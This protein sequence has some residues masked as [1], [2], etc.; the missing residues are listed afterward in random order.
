MRRR[1][2]R[3]TLGRNGRANNLVEPSALRGPAART[4]RRVPLDSCEARILTNCPRTMS[5]LDATTPAEAALVRQLEQARALHAE[6]A[7]NP[8]LD[9][10]MERLAD[11]QSRRLAQTYA[12]LAAQ[13]RYRQ[14]IAFFRSDL[15]GGEEMARARRGPRARRADAC[16][17]RCPSASS[18]RSRSRWSSTCSRRSSIGCCSAGCRAPTA[19]SRVAE[20]C[21]AYRRAANLPARRRQI[22]LIGA[23]RQGARPLREE[24]DGARRACDDA[25]ARAARRLRGAARLPR[26]GL[27]CVRSHGR[28]RR[29]P[30]DDPGARDRDP[31]GD[32]RRRRTIRS[33]IR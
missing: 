13:P 16:R 8:I 3:S 21:R 4:L 6:R 14:A 12:D 26:S 1:I 19:R 28:R 33:P 29:V 30:R 11:W 32:R 31:R 20:Y 22:E 23:D 7:A 18:A 5:Q 10:A 27:R 2:R 9:G 17:P 15:Y 24:A 25:A